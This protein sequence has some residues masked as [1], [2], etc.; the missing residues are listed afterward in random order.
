MKTCCRLT[1]RG[2]RGGK[3]YCV[4]TLAGK[5]ASLNTGS[6]EEVTT[7]LRMIQWRQKINCGFNLRE[8][9]IAK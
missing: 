2:A 4:D 1:C 8:L 3:F 9:R 6:E 7:T 5:R